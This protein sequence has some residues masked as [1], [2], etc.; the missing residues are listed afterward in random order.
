M[1]GYILDHDLS[2]SRWSTTYEILPVVHALTGCDITF[3]IF[4]IGK[5]SVDRLI[6]SS[7]AELSDL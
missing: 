2:S 5:I 7:S 1:V 6:K 4:C 3:A